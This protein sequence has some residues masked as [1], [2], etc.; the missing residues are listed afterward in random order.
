MVLDIIAKC[1]R[2]AAMLSGGETATPMQEEN[3]INTLAEQIATSIPFHLDQTFHIREP[4]PTDHSPFASSGGGG[5]AGLLLL[6]PLWVLV[7]IDSVPGHI[8][9]LAR[10]TLVWIQKNIGIGQAGLLGD[11]SVLCSNFLHAPIRYLW[12]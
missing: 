9:L 5:A 11:V 10:K 6:H 12:L 2:K 3:D 4:W 7:T 8:R 1:K